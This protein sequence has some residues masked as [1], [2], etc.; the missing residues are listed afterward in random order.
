MILAAGVSFPEAVQAGDFQRVGLISGIAMP[1]ANI[2]SWGLR[3]VRPALG[4][5]A[6]KI[7]WIH[8]RI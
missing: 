8:I 3:E 1:A 7:I 4:R 6:F 5:I 2:I